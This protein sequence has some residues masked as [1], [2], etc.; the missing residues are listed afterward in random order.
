[1][2]FA[3]PPRAAGV[4][5]ISIEFTP[6]VAGAEDP[7]V[8]F[9]AGSSRAIQVPV[10][11]GERSV[12]DTI[13]QSGTTAGRLTLRV[14]VGGQVLERQV[15]VAP[16]PVS[17]DRVTASRTGIGVQVDIAGFDNTR[18]ASTVAFR[19]YDAA[20]KLLGEGPV[21]ANVSGAFAQYF[22]ESTV[23]GMFLL[24]AS[25]PVAGDSSQVRAVE[26]EATNSAGVAKAAR[27]SF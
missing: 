17:I 25:F 6:L 18:T 14:Q 4:A 19:F 12:P 3:E 20:G 23:G 13:F 11:I 7:A 22:Q 8:F 16:A 5:A 27:V 26:V 10:K 21:T 1:V 2:Q 9:L 24:R 15:E